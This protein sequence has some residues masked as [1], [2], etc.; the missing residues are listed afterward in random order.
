M[1][2]VALDAR[3]YLPEA[4]AADGDRMARAGVPDGVGCSA[5]FGSPL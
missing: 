4:W 1:Q 5:T 3:L 2:V